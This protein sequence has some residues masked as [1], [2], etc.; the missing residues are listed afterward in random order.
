MLILGYNVTVLVRDSA[1]VEPHAN[2]TIVQ[3]SVTSQ[4]DLD[5]VFAGAAV[6]VDAVLSF[7]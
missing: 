5:K 4:D 2:L 3:G 7:H 6:P 1:A